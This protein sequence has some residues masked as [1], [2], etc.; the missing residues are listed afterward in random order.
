MRR[1]LIK[2]GDWLDWLERQGSNPWP[3]TTNH[4]QIGNFDS[5]NTQNKLT[6]RSNQCILVFGKLG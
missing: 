4:G 3:T 6:T 5:E 2:L 1:A